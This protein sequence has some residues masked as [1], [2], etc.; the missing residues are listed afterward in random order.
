MIGNFLRLS[1]PKTTVILDF[2]RL[3]RFN[4]LKTNKIHESKL[5]F[6]KLFIDFSIEI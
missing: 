6:L 4:T 2:I 1:S 3:N 5:K